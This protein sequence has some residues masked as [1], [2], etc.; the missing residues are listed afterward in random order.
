M[1]KIPLAN[2]NFKD[3]MARSN[4]KKESSRKLSGMLELEILK[5]RSWFFVAFVLLVVVILSLLFLSN[6]TYGVDELAQRD[7][8]QNSQ[9]VN[10][11]GV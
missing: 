2:F 3:I 9:T 11:P 4:M 10:I 7:L 1:C 8:F 6:V 5:I